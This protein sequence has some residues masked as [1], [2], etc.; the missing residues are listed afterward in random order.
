MPVGW[1]AGSLVGGLGAV[2]LVLLRQRE[3]P[4]PPETWGL[5]V[6]VVIA[7]ALAFITA[8]LAITLMMRWLRQ[9]SYTPFVIYRLFLGAALLYW[10]RG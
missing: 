7:A 2:A 5:R 3:S 10:F 4:W 9:A 6:G 8:L 1:I